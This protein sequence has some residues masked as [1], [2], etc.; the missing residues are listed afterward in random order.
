MYQLKTLRRRVGELERNLKAEKQLP[1]TLSRILRIFDLTLV[2]DLLDLMKRDDEHGSL[3]R[4]SWLCVKEWYQRNPT[5]STIHI[6]K[7]LDEFEASVKSSNHTGDGHKIIL[8]VLPQMTEDGVGKR[9]LDNSYYVVGGFVYWRNI[10]KTV[11][12]KGD[13]NENV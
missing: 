8:S 13:G 11:D 1:I 3:A 2:V 6:L 9:V 4:R 10:E 7:Q 12:A 5:V